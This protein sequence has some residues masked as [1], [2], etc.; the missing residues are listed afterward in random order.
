MMITLNGGVFTPVPREGAAEWHARCENHYAECEQMQIIRSAV[1]ELLD[2]PCDP[3]FRIGATGLRPES[4]R[5]SR[6]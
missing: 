6:P 4:A 1:T 5:D 3:L 2:E